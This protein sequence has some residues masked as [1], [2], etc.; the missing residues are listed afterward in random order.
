MFF[1]ISHYHYFLLIFLVILFI[2]IEC[3]FLAFK[4]TCV[5]LLHLSWMLVFLFC[6]T[7]S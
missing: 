5:M 6:E 4:N 1:K 2:L 7:M 3:H